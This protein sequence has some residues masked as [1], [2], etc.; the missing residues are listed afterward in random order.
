MLLL[1]TTA[2]TGAEGSV[3]ARQTTSPIA[4]PPTST[5][6]APWPA[7]ADASARA[8]AAGLPVLR[9][10]QLKYHVHAHLD[11]IVDGERKP[12]P[13]GIGIDGIK[14]LISPLHTHDATGIIHIENE[15][16]GSFTLG[17][18]FIEWGVRL[19][20]DCVG[21]YCGRPESPLRV[22]VNGQ[23]ISG[24]PTVIELK[25]HDEIALI[26]GPLVSI[27]DHFDFPEG[28]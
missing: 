10:E 2:C 3:V 9:T 11:I 12:V 15:K 17:Q 7:P 28:E 1:S 16:P 4:M 23:R 8:I 21:G 22:F 20:G 5:E 18:L 26:V 13:P 25:S 14:H 27:P 24:D 6:S 19:T